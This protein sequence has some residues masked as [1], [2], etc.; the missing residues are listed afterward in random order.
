MIIWICSIFISYW[1]V[2][3]INC[4]KKTIADLNLYKK[5]QEELIKKEER[6]RREKLLQEEKEDMRKKY[7][8][9]GLA[10]SE[11]KNAVRRLSYHE[12][13]GHITESEK[14]LLEVL[15]ASLKTNLPLSPLT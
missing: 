5:N 6:R 15:K 1:I 9:L 3:T 13:T 11:Q 7:P 4:Y 2:N 12:R 8:E 14:E 10:Y